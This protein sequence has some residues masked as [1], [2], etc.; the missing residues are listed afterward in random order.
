MKVYY[1]SVTQCPLLHWLDGLNPHPSS[2]LSKRAH[3]Q[4]KQ[5]VRLR[6]PEVFSPTTQDKQW[7]QWLCGGEAHH[8]TAHDWEEPRERASKTG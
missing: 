3:L 1:K 4:S 5:N 7:Q 2:H 6:E 8:V